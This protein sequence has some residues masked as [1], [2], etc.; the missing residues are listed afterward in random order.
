MPSMDNLIAEYYAQNDSA[1]SDV[2]KQAQVELFAKLAADNGIDLEQLSEDQIGYL[3]N[4]TFKTAA[5]ESKKDEH[6]E[7]ESASEEHEEEQKKEKAAAAYEEFEEKRAAAAKIAEADFLGRYMAHAMTDEIQKIA[8][9]GSHVDSAIKSVREGAKHVGDWASRAGKRVGDAASGASRRAGELVTGSR[10]RGYRDTMRDAHQS[11]RDYARFGADMAGHSA[12]TKKENLRR[13]AGDIATARKN[14]TA[15]GRKVK[16][17]RAALAGTALAGSALA[18]H[19]ASKHASAIDE[20]AAEEAVV[21]A[22]SVGWDLDEAVER[23]SSVL[24]LGIGESE[25]VAFAQDLEGAV[26]V[27]SL[28]LLEAAGYPVTWND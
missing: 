21:K 4:E 1:D 22:A 24:T 26:D 3:W 18:G 2:E 6:E 11:A 10:E 25:K 15:E 19:E 23:V 9:A 7:H 13:T 27:R 12:S 17:T 28:E 14:M 8:S 20:L 5:E 16:A